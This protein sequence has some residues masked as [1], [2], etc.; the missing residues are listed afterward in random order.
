MELD[1]VHEVGFQFNPFLVYSV[2]AFVKIMKSS[3]AD[4]LK[5][6]AA[7][8]CLGI[9]GSEEEGNKFARMIGMQVAK[10][11]VGDL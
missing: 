10:K 7:T 4:Y 8:I 9:L 3:R 11:N 2:E 1:Q 5:R 6:G